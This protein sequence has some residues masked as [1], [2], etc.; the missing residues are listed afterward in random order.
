MYR[1]VYAVYFQHA[2]VTPDEG[3]LIHSY[4]AVEDALTGV[5]LRVRFELLLQRKQG[6]GEARPGGG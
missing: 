5:A 6:V 4:R 1:P 3:F 2:Q